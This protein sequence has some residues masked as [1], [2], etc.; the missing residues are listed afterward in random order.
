MFFTGKCTFLISSVIADGP[1]NVTVQPGD[2][3]VFACVGYANTSPELVKDLVITWHID[4]QFIFDYPNLNYTKSTNLDNHSGAF[5]CSLTV[6][7]SLG[8]AN[9]TI[10]CRVYDLNTITEH[11]VQAA[12][13]ANATISIATGE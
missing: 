9:S 2:L 8:I 4:G 12:F 6:V 10:Q 7:A 11:F 13:S 3:A 1:A 5:N